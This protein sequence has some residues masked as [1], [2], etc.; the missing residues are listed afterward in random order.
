MNAE[1]RGPGRPTD[2]DLERRILEAA[3]TRLAISG[4][5][6]M[7]IAEV[8]TDAGVSRPTVYKR[9]P[10]KA[11]LVSAALR[12]SR[13]TEEAAQ[14]QVAELPPVEA[15]RAML[16]IFADVVARP[17]GIGLF[18][19]VLLED[20]YTPGL[21]DQLREHI[22]EPGHQQLVAAVA[23]AQREGVVAANL[24]LDSL[25]TMLYGAVLVAYLRE[26]AVSPATADRL[27]AA[28]WPALV[29]GQ[30]AIDQP[31]LDGR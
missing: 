25:V 28:I 12:Y 8:A 10:T 15:I 13:A 2:P 6:R 17:E 4:Y 29:A 14:R 20:R 26:G 7:T 16:R 18:A 3:R 27:V 9:W 24:D 23:R 19:S 1:R 11:E 31:P 30:T 21:M 5:A 22:I